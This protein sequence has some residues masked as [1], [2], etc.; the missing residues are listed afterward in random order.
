MYKT[1]R[2]VKKTLLSKLLQRSVKWEDAVQKIL[3]GERY[4][5]DDY[6]WWSKKSSY[7]PGMKS[8]NSIIRGFEQFKSIVYLEANNGSRVLF[9]MRYSAW[10]NTSRFYF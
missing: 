5:D 7:A 4:G 2:V 3:V 1:F 10:I 9:W 8:W 6:V